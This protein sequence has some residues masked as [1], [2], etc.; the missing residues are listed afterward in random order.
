MF[1]RKKGYYQGLFFLMLTMI[2]SCA[3]DILTKFMGQR[4][5]SIEVTFFRFFFGLV[6]LLPFACTIGKSIF[7]TKQLGANVL[8]GILGA[9]SFLMYT[10]SIVHVQLV[11]VVAILWTIPLF[12]LVLSAIFLKENVTAYRWIATII[13]FV[14]LSFITLYDSESFVALKL[15][16]I[17]PIAAA[18]LFAVQDVMIKKLVSNENQITMLLYFDIVTSLFT[19]AP[20]IFVWDTPTLFELSMLFVLGANGNIMQYLLF[21]AYNATDLSALA[22]YRYVEFVLSAIFAF[23]FFLEIPGINVLIGTV[24]LIPST[25]YLAYSEKRKKRANTASMRQSAAN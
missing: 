22:P 2:V 5:N 23:I 8:R 10:Y 1:L 17:A 20:A 9:I 25:L 7:R 12:I 24:I 14:G 15:L 13:G 18:F 16:Y 6:T 19:L 21:K 3:N 11:E 4:L